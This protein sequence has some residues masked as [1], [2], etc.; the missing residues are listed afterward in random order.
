MRRLRS[1]PTNL[2]RPQAKQFVK[3]PFERRSLVAKP[4]LI[5]RCESMLPVQMVLDCGFWHGT[6]SRSTFPNKQFICSA[7]QSDH[8]RMGAVPPT[9]WPGGKTGGQLWDG[10]IRRTRPPP[11]MAKERWQNASCLRPTSDL[12]QL[13]I[14]FSGSTISPDFYL[15]RFRPARLRPN[16]ACFNCRPAITTAKSFQTLTPDQEPS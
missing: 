2:R 8:L 7:S 11:V 16:C 5:W 1:R 9:L 14:W 4:I 13:P 12:G 6:W 15:C 10:G 3:S